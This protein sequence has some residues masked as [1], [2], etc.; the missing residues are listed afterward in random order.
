MTGPDIRATRAALGLT[1][2]DLA[3]A[4]GVHRV[5]LAKWEGGT[6]EPPHTVVLVLQHM[7]RDAKTIRAMPAAR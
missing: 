5:T 6:H 1:Q 4:L 2:A 7:L 3:E